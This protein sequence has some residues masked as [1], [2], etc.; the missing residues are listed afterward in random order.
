M[1]AFQLSLPIPGCEP[2]CLDDRNQ[3]KNSKHRSRPI[4]IESSCTTQRAAALLGVSTTTLYRARKEGK[5]YQHKAWIAQ[6][7]GAKNAWTVSYTPNQ[8]KP[9]N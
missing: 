9:N 8:A 7:I 1:K 2:V 5:P 4:V 6:A 3:P